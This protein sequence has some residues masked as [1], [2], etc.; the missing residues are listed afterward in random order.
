MI[1]LEMV[2]N[3][4]EES[5][6]TIEQIEAFLS[7]SAVIDF[8]VASDDSERYGHISRV[9][10]HFDYPQ[11][12]KRERGILHRCLQHSSGYSRAQVTRLMSRWQDPVAGT[13]VCAGHQQGVSTAGAGLLHPRPLKQHESDHRLG[14]HDH[15]VRE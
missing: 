6:T 1:I 15:Q 13:G 14:S 2:I 4:N 10:R 11:R 9:L 12:S 5:L 7:G 8:S 3:M